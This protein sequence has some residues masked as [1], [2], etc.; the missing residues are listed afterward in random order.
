MFK[1]AKQNYGKGW[2][3]WRV[4]ILFNDL[5]IGDKLAE[6]KEEGGGR[7][8]LLLKNVTN[9]HISVYQSQ[10]TTGT[11]TTLALEQ[12]SGNTL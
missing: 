7:I 6:R 10:G 12:L 5:G 1:V 4:V 3:G 2:V 8:L 11:T 9:I